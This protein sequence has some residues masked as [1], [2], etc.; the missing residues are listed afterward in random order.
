MGGVTSYE[1][2]IEV[3]Y[4]GLW[5][6]VCDDLWTLEDTHVACR[7]LGFGPAISALTFSHFGF[8]EG[9]VWLDE[10]G[11]VGTEAG[12]SDCPHLGWAAGDCTHIEDAGV[13]CSGKEITSL[14]MMSL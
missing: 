8:G 6:T 13:R 12:L 11:C 3:F 4:N 14:R 1:G 10:V 2:R 9:V 7:Q 5:G